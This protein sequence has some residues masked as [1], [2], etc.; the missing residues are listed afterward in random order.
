[1]GFVALGRPDLRLRSS[2]VMEERKGREMRDVMLVSKCL[3]SDA[4]GRCVKPDHWV[5][6]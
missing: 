3:P 4:K 6:S 2:P 1:M 5:P